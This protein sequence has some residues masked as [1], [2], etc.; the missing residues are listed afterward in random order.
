MTHRCMILRNSLRLW[1]HTICALLVYVYQWLY[2]LRTCLHSILNVTDRKQENKRHKNSHFPPSDIG[3]IR[4]K[5]NKT[6]VHFGSLTE[7]SLAYPSFYKPCH[8]EILVVPM[9]ISNV[10]KL[11][12]FQLWLCI[13]A[14][15]YFSPKN[16]PYS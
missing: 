16:T 11:N 2:L 13:F 4:N 3:G 8:A 6:S 15:H 9:Q 12:R 7:T 5:Q 10:N 1:H 14:N